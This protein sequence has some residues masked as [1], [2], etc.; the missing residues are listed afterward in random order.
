M[1]LLQHLDNGF[2]DRRIVRGIPD[3]GI[4]GHIRGAGC[5]AG[6]AGACLSPDSFASPDMLFPMAISFL[7]AGY[8]NGVLSRIGPPRTTVIEQALRPAALHRT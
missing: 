4:D 5:C 3:K 1:I 6:P 2:G 8:V 7:R